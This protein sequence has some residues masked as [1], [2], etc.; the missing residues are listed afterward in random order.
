MY[1]GRPAT[2]VEVTTSNQEHDMDKTSMKGVAT[3]VG[4]TEL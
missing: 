2:D 1:T 3:Y 4:V